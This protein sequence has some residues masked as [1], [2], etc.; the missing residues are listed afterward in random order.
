MVLALT[1]LNILTLRLL[2]GCQAR[3][4]HSG[5]PVMFTSAMTRT[6]MTPTETTL[7]EPL[8]APNLLFIPEKFRRKRSC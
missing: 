7:T 4:W 5:S 2:V 1:L 6:E 8:T 3:S